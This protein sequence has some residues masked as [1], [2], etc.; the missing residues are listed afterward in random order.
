MALSLSQAG[1]S[2]LPVPENQIKN[3]CNKE[4]M[5]A[6]IKM[7]IEN[8]GGNPTIKKDD[9]IL[10]YYAGHGAEAKAPSGWSC[11]NEK[12]QMLVPH[13]F[14]PSGSDNHDSMHGQGV[15]DERLTHLLRDDAEKKSDNI[16]VI[17]ASCH[18]TSGT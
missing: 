14:N 1:I 16:T 3:L 8:L 11:A 12:M 5:R 13:D 6:I 4:A 17:L 15:L 18:S 7:E 10:I 2:L 9:P